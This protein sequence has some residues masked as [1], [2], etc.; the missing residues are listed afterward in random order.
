MVANVVN[1]GLKLIPGFLDRTAQEQLREMLDDVVT[2]APFYTPVM[3]RTGRPF[4]IE[5][6]NAGP[7]G[8]VSDRAGYRYQ[9]SHPLTA[10][11]WPDIP[12]AIL[13]AWADLSNYPDPPECCLINRY[14]SSK[15]RMGLHRDQDEEDLTAPVVSLSLGDTAL[16]R[17]GGPE[18]KGPTRSFR[19]A[20]GDALVLAGPS[21]LHY[22]GI[23]RIMPGTSTLLPDG[24]RINLTLRRVT[25][26]Q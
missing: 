12:G 17:I 21:R 3:P 15:S 26:P 11:P 2:A 4:S 25:K 18:R 14:R 6:T 23:E 5:M 9:T 7:L 22:H 8:W 20:S 10:K 16:F 19:L 24:G 1:E 13:D